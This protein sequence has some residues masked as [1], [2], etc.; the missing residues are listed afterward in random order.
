MLTLAG[1]MDKATLAGVHTHMGN[2]SPSFGGKKNQVSRLKSAS[3]DRRSCAELGP[4]VAGQFQSIK[5]INGHGQAA[6][7]EAFPDGFPSPAIGGPDESAC[8]L[9]DLI[10]QD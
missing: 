6:A 8:G 2:A 3:L 4:G 10:T 9:N 1:G 7:V 5:A